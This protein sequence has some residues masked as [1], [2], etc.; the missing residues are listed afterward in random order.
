MDDRVNKVTYSS[1]HPI[2]SKREDRFNRAPFA[3]RVADTTAT[4]RDPSS[5]VIGLYGPWGDGKSSTL[6]LMEEALAAHSNVV[7]VRFNPWLFNSEE[8][9]LRGF[10]DTVAAALGRASPSLA[11]KIGSLLRDYGSLLLS[12]SFSAAAA[13]SLE[14]GDAGGDSMASVRLDELKERVEEVLQKAGKRVVVLID[15]IDR[16]DRAE[17][18]AIFKLVKLSASFASTS[19]V[20]AFD[21]EMVA[22]SIGERYAQ[23]GYEAGRNYLAK[24]IQVPLHL[25]P[26]DAMQLRWMVFDGIATALHQS[27]IELAEDQTDA[28]AHHFVR[29]LEARLDTPRKAK[30]YVNAATFALPLLKEEVHPVDL[31]LIEGIRI[32]YPKLYLA[33]RDNAD[34]FL[35]GGRDSDQN[36]ESAQRR[37]I[38]DLIAEATGDMTPEQSAALR[39]D[40]LEALFPRL[41]MTRYGQDWEATWAREQRI[42][43]E[44]YFHRYFA[45]SVPPGDIGDLEVKS[46]LGSIS[47]S[48]APKQDAALQAFARRGAFSR[49]VHKLHQAAPTMQADTA[50]A[51]ALAIARNASLLYGERTRTSMLDSTLGHASR[52][53][54][55]LVKQTP[56][57]QE[58]SPIA[59]A[60]AETAEPM[61]FAF[62][63]LRA[64]RRTSDRAQE[65]QL[66]SE[67]GDQAMRS[68]LVDRIRSQAAATP[69]HRAFGRAARGLY[70]LWAQQSSAEVAS[71]LRQKIQ[72]DPA[73]VDAFLDSYVGEV[74]EST[75]GLPEDTAISRETYEAIAELVDP[76]DVA[77]ALVQRH[78]P[79]LGSG[80]FYRHDVS[81]A[82]Q[83]IA[84]QFLWMH[85]RAIEE[86][87]GQA[88]A[89]PETSAPES[90]PDPPIRFL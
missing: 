37:G 77:A 70:W 17:L 8:R 38:G 14:A 27:G 4:R 44:Q 88:A 19:Y 51:L 7:V 79:D 74:R 13:R 78:G 64:M 56:E 86:S 53:V 24:I 60:I 5:I 67:D 46:L 54:T 36:M 69:L 50:S 47:S 12:A 55:S 6:N 57:V 34:L 1:D 81:S 89:M 72:A 22:S 39:G 9:L 11:E 49:L 61:T 65:D 75:D 2:R 31:L 3:M 58:R 33:I 35:G 76:E 40:L 90:T 28:F 21:D 23:A 87:E 84:H 15:D 85:H 83:R 80:D 59:R 20:L 29:G 45:Y 10:F 66:L 16:L 82:A 42:C 41:R 25:P 62:E 63:C 18:Q 30:L 68:A 32:F 43:S 52:L 26:P 73:E 48:S 71:D